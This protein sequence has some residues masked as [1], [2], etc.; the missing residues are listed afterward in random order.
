[1]WPWRTSSADRPG[2]SFSQALKMGSSDLRCFSSVTA[3][4]LFC[5]FVCLIGWATVRSRRRGSASRS[6]MFP[7]AVGL[8]RE[9]EGCMWPWTSH[10][11]AH[12]ARPSLWPAGGSRIR[13]PR[14]ADAGGQPRGGQVWRR[15]PGEG[16]WV[17]ECRSAEG[18]WPSPVCARTPHT[19]APSAWTSAYFKF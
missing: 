9:P 4:N 18:A 12:L 6:E 19:V 5:L 2:F 11:T 14:A 7:G 8:F 13:D 16:G 15:V 17:G 1:M 10:C 3:I